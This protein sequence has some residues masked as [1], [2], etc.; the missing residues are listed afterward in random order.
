MYDRKQDE[1]EEH[2][3]VVVFGLTIL[4]LIIVFVAWPYLR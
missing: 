3:L 2:P 1:Q 4:I